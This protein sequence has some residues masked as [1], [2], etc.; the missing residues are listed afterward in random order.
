LKHA[1]NKKEYA[2]LLL[3]QTFETPI[4]NLVNTFFNQKLLK[5][6]IMMIQKNKSQKKSLLKYFLSAPLFVL[7]LILSS[8]TI[9]HDSTKSR[10]SALAN[11]KLQATQKPKDKVFT[12]VEKA[13][14]YPGGLDKFYKFLGANIH[15]PAE[16]REKK[17]EGKVFISFIVEED[18]SLSNMKILR[19]PGYGSGK[20]TVRVMKLSPKWIPGV[21]NG[22]KVR[23]QYTV[24][25]AFT[26]KA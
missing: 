4:N 11:N 19:E 22:K 25:V 9:N 8:A 10:S 16:M 20:E 7:M 12:E 17:V 2:M 15:Y 14:S 21:Q 24:P 26:L 6:R 23:V 5:Q 18:G 13:P 1:G 3:S